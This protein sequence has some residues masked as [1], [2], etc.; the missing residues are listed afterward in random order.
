MIE[1][2]DI[3]LARYRLD[4]HLSPTPLEAAPELGDRVW[5][6]L[7]NLNLT[8]S[9]KIRGALNAVLSLSEAER[10]RGVLTV[11]SGNHAQAVAYAAHLTGTRARIFMPAHTP[12]K[13]VKGVQRYG[14][15]ALLDAVNYNDAERAARRLEAEEGLTF[16][17]PYNDARVV[18]GAGTIGLEILDQLPE[19]ERV[20]VCVGGGG[21]L[22]GV[23]LALKALRPDIEIIGVNAQAAPAMYNFFYGTHHPEVWQT[24]AE[25]LSGDIEDGSVTLAPTRQHVA[26]MVLVSEDHIAAAIRF[27]VDAHG[28]IVEGGGAVSVA[29]VQ[30]GL[31]VAD[32]RPTVLLVSGGNID[33]DVLR[34]VLA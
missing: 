15:E 28:W 31:I 23:T 32:G 8:R 33:G 1:L 29:A 9:F 10:A 26:Q 6:K 24:L 27:L 5:L 20:V 7:E 3:A 25:A 14:A 21:L 19:V 17:S 4:K 16:L 12:A 13:K 34:G 18:A 30:H 2:A 22:A 11:S